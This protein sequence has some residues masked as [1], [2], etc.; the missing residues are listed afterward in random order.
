M[1]NKL[2][3]PFYE[4]PIFAAEKRLEDFSYNLYFSYIFGKSVEQHQ[5]LQDEYIDAFLAQ[6]EAKMQ[7]LNIEIALIEG[8][9][10]VTANMLEANEG[11]YS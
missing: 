10:E 6:D 2:S 7:R 3:I 1:K 9:F 5:Q 8:A 4:G 11:T